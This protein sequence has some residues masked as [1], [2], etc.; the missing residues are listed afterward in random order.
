MPSSIGQRKPGRIL[1]LLASG[2]GKTH[3]Q[4][5]LGEKKRL[6]GKIRIRP[7]THEAGRGRSLRAQGNPRPRITAP[8]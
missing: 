6:R 3:S 8:R 5:A 2:I 7:M 4:P 1:L